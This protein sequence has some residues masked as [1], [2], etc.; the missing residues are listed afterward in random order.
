MLAIIRFTKSEEHLYG[1]VIQPYNLRI[2]LGTALLWFCTC[3][4]HHRRMG[5]ALR[6]SITIGIEYPMQ[7]S[8]LHSWMQKSVGFRHKQAHL[9]YALSLLADTLNEVQ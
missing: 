6:M 1:N 3:E 2:K 5:E 7:F 8:L 9:D 4:T